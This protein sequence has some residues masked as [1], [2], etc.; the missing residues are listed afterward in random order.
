[1]ILAAHQNNFIPWLS[2]FSK[3]QKCDVFV[4]MSHCQ[5]EKN[6]FTNRCKVRGKWWTKPVFKGNVLIKE[7]FY[8]DETSLY[9][10]NKEWVYT[11]ALTLGID[12]KKIV[13]DFE[14]EKT[15]TDRIIELCQHFA[16]DEYMTNMEA[17][18]KY[19]DV[20]KMEKAGIAVVPHEFNYKKHTFE[21]FEE[22]GIEGTQRL[23]RK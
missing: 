17:V 9:Q 23:I 2:Y 4:L 18:E 6:G 7:K 22:F 19:L 21:A 5:F 1:M 15:G 8:T 20:E 10:V 14:T 13:D 16:C 12:T 3:M 11:I